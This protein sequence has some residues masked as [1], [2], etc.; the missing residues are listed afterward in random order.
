MCVCVCEVFFCTQLIMSVQN[1]VAFS[2]KYVFL[3]IIQTKN[4]QHL[5]LNNIVYIV[6][7]P[8]CFDAL[9]SSSV[10]L[11]FLLCLSYKNC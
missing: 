4:A 6:S 5:C 7:T 3:F 2:D 9:A 11:I 10:G 1:Q 8:T